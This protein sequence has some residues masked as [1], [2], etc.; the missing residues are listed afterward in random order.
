MGNAAAKFID[1]LQMQQNY[2][3]EIMTGSSF[4][5]TK[6]RLI[7]RELNLLKLSN[8]YINWKY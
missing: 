6:L 3:I 7:Y 5:R 2:I 8:I 4:I 1:K